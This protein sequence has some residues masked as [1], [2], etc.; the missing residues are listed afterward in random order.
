MMG[1]FFRLGRTLPVVSVLALS[2]VTPALAQGAPDVR[3]LSGGLTAKMLSAGQNCDAT[4][5]TVAVELAN[6]SARPV[7]VIFV[8]QMSAVDNAGVAYRLRGYAGTARCKHGYVDDCLGLSGRGV[9]VP[10]EQFT[11]LDPGTS[12]VITFDLWHSSPKKGTL[13][14]VSADYGYR[15]IDPGKEDTLTDSE[16]VRT[17]KKMNAGL[18]P[19]PLSTVGCR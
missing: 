5:M 2:M 13:V 1:N 4:S 18:S 8:E 9:R 16:K 10:L 7:D 11:R 3:K 12:A 15:I 14:T 19:Y 17:V 6:P